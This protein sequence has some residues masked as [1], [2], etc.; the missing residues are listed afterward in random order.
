[1][2]ILKPLGFYEKADFA[3]QLYRFDSGFGGCPR[4]CPT[5]LPALL[6][7]ISHWCYVVR[8]HALSI[9]VTFDP[10]LFAVCLW[11]HRFQPYV[12]TLF[13]SRDESPL[14]CSSKTHSGSLCHDPDF[15]AFRLLCVV[16]VFCSSLISVRFFWQQL[17]CWLGWDAKCSGL[18]NAGWTSN[19]VARQQ[20]SL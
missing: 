8:C 12:M 20:C 15:S 9:G 19:I 3:V 14:T 11:H 6:A 4:S 16:L 18:Q 7:C 5:D 13:R 2:I 17:Y 10:K 1:M